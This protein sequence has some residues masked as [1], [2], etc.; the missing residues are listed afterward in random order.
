VFEINLAKMIAIAIEK[1]FLWPQ[2][3]Q[4]LAPN[5]NGVLTSQRYN[6]LWRT[7]TNG[8][9]GEGFPVREQYSNCCNRY[10]IVM[11][12]VPKDSRVI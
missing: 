7:L 1:T 8:L 12:K 5:K 9:I 3:C 11:L 4:N 6:A 10:M 2:E